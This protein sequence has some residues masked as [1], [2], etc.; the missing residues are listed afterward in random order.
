[1][2]NNINK[3]SQKPFETFKRLLRYVFNYKKMFIFGMITL[4]IALVATIYTSILVGPIAKSL[5]EGS[6]N[7]I[8]IAVSNL[9][10]AVAASI[11]FNF[12]GNTIFAVLAQKVTYNIRKKLFAHLEKLDIAFFDNNKPGEIVSTFTNDVAILTEALDQAISKSIISILE[13]TISIIILIKINWML[14][15]IT[16]FLLM[17]YTFL[18]RFFG[19][20]SKY[21][22]AISQKKLADLTSYSEEMIGGMPI[23]KSYNYEDRNVERFSVKVDN[24]KKYQTKST[25]YGI[26]MNIIG[27]SFAFILS[28]VITVLGVYF[29]N[30][31][32]LDISN[33]LIYIKFVSSLSAPI[34]S[35]SNY[36]SL[37]YTALAG[38]ERIFNILD[39]KPEIDEGTI[40]LIEKDGNRYW[41]NNGEFIKAEGHV[42]FKNVYFNYDTDM[43]DKDKMVLR[44][45]SLYAKPKEKLAFVGST[46][47]G[48]TTISNLVDRFYDVSDGEILIDGLPI[49]NIKKSHLRSNMTVVLQE[50]TIFTGTVMENIRKGNLNA[51]DEDIIKA[52]KLTNADYIISRLPDG[53]NT[54]L[55]PEDISLSKG[56][57]QFISIARAAVSNPLILMLDEATS[58]IDSL[59]EKLIQ[60]G[61]DNLMKN[62]TTLVIAHR[63]STVKNANSILVV[64]DGQI[65]ERGPHSD[66]IA[67]KGKYYN[68]YTG[69]EILE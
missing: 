43:K 1:M 15:I 42:E 16:I 34:Q 24:L 33:L 65:I 53:Y 58:S 66:L 29:Y 10:I 32:V 49:N 27:G 18:I 55:S 60:E 13:I 62:S 4:L 47:A 36:I 44:D 6:L 12:L 28:S 46:G 40:T 63:L 3:E 19:N 52:A 17:V 20:K 14:S 54:M 11:I 61:F 56:E 22:T 69:K 26:S 48:K 59:T 8:N 37:I 38:A 45:I 31:G 67:K 68:L 51:S 41:N 9:A 25:I 5:K 21:Y 30:K 39:I 50:P 7:G 2:N 35:L 23:I 57:K 64:E